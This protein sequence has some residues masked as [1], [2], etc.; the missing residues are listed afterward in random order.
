[1]SE[2]NIRLLAGQMESLGI[3]KAVES[4]LS[5]AISFK[6]ERFELRDIEKESHFTIIVAVQFAAFGEEDYT[7]PYYDV[8]LRKAVVFST[9]LIGGIDVAALDQQMQ[10][11]EWTAQ[12]NRKFLRTDMSLPLLEKSHAILDIMQKLRQIEKSN[13]IAIANL[14]RFK[15]WVDTPLESLIPGLPMVKAQYEVTQRFYF[16]EGEQPISKNEA[17]RFLNIQLMGKQMLAKKKAAA[18]SPEHGANDMTEDKHRASGLLSKK[19]RIP[20]KKITRS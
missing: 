20:R 9:D 8:T 16:F 1:M 11:I 17:V 6:P 4:A 18:G 19:K 5:A 15:H 10:A 3:T 7:V 12:I 13:G 14:L 2:A